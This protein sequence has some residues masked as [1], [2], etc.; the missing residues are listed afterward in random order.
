[1]YI[2]KHSMTQASNKQTALITGASA[3]LGVEFA[4][5][6]AQDGISMI[7]VARRKARLEDLAAELRAQHPSLTVWII[8][9]DLASPGAGSALFQKVQALQTPVH[10]LVNNAGVGVARSVSEQTI[11]QALNMVD[12]N[13]RSVVELIHSFLPVFLSRNSGRILNVGSV[14]GFQPGPYMATYY[15]TKAFVNSMS[16]ALT[17]ELKGTAVTCTLL[18]P[19]PTATEFAEVAGHDKSRLFLTGSSFLVSNAKS[20]A[21]AGYRGMQCGAS[22]VIP[23]WTN[24]WIV[25]SLRISPRSLVRKLVAR[26]NRG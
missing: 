10:Y 17:E 3:G 9:H 20:V 8:E 11:D 25:Q 22:L 26:L 18:A 12:L 4:R 19:G 16:E 5:L 7:L 13:V 24:R 1:M 15:A 2:V 14:A 23:G 6:F 21:R